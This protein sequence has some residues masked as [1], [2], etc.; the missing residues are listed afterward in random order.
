M[1]FLPNSDFRSAIAKQRNWSKPHLI[2]YQESHDEER[3]MYKNI[4]FGNISNGSHNVRTPAVAL[5]R[6]AMAAAFW[7]MI[8]GPKM[9]WQFGELGYDY[10]ITYCPSTSSVP[11]PYPNMQC[12]TDMKPPRWD[13]RQDP[14][15]QKLWNVYSAMLQLRNTPNFLA[16]FTTNRDVESYLSGRIKTLKV[17]SDSLKVVVVG[18]FDVTPSTDTVSFPGSGIWYDYLNQ[19]TFNAT[20]TPQ[21]ITLQPGEYHVYL[22]RNVRNTL[23]TSLT[24]IGPDIDA[25]TLVIYPNPVSSRAT[26]NYEMPVSGKIEISIWNLQGRKL[27][28]IYSGM[29]SKGSHS[30]SWDTKQQGARMPSGQYLMVLDMN[31]RRTHK[32]FLII[33]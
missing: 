3:L 10:S 22:N 23:V 20:G 7:S 17:W 18:N 11:Q 8:P 21:N 25:G 5:E 29:K 30:V 12:R 26:L 27:S 33:D 14:D 31:G 16:T 4:N 9:M 6:N 15:R 19:T 24:D 1:G 32:T 13:Y 2:A 28:T